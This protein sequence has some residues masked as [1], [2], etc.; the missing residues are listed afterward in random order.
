MRLQ[1]DNSNNTKFR[2]IG[3]GTEVFHKLIEEHKYYVDKT[4]LLRTVF[5]ENGAEVLLITRP[6][7][8]GKTITLSTFRDFLSLDHT[9]PGDISRQE[10]WFQET[11]IYSDRDFCQNYMGRFPVISLSLKSVSFDNSKARARTTMP[12]GRKPSSI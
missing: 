11:A 9:S 7:R 6:R 2:P 1:L 8:F 10:K 3:I 5:Q 12:P 4:L